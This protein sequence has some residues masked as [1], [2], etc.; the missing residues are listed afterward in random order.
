MLSLN[1]RLGVTIEASQHRNHDEDKPE[2]KQQVD[3][4]KNWVAEWIETG[5]VPPGK[6]DFIKKMMDS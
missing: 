1:G 3:K 6:E 2:V 5:K 4:P